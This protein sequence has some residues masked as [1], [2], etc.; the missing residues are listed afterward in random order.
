MKK[1]VKLLIWAGVIAVA[2]II[3]QFIN[4]EYYMHLLVYVMMYIMLTQGLNLLTGYLGQLSL[5]HQTFLGIGAYTSA[6]LA[7]KAGFPVW[8]GIILGGVFGAVGSF[9]ISR[10]T[11]RVRGSYFVVMTTAFVG[12]VRLFINNTTALTNGPMGLRAVP[13]LS[14]FGYTFLTKASYY[15]LGVVLA[16]ITVYVCY[17]IAYSRTGRAF[18]ALREH[19]QLANSVGISF[20]YYL[21]I[22]AVVGGFFAGIAGGYYAH[23]AQFLSP[24]VLSHNYTITMLLMIV[25]G[26]KG[27]IVGPL[28]GAIIFTFVPELLRAYEDYRLPIYGAILILSVLCMPQGISPLLTQLWYRITKHTPKVAVQKG[29]Q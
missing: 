7:M 24:D 22:S 19:E 14:L 25:I 9:L 20:S 27:T 5:G 1:Q 23:Y 4:S 26:G 11:F 3:P 21:M 10:V 6:L 12:I 16:S 2:L 18:V 28:L 8:S 17:R 15:Y 29:E 13:P